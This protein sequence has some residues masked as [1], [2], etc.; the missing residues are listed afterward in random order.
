MKQVIYYFLTTVILLGRA[1]PGGAEEKKLQTTLDVTYMS[2]LMDKGGK[3]YGEQGGLLETV[4]IDLWGTGFG[5]KIGHREAT[6]GGYVNKERFDY[7]LYYGC[8]LL[9]GQVGETSA[10][11]SAIYHQFPDEPKEAGN[12]YEWELALAW[13]NLLPCGLV[14]N[15]VAACEYAAGSGYGNRAASGWY[16]QF[17]LAYA[18][19]CEG[20][21]NSLDLSAHVAYR[22]GLGGGPVDHDWSHANF[23]VSTAFAAPGGLTL[24]PAINYEIAMDKSVIDADF[25]YFVLSVKK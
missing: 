22:D 8:S 1:G 11:L 4:G 6:S 9:Q 2:R 14:P 21:Q 10:Q 7:V 23:G 25:V 15:Y 13:P 5:A 19:D 3:Y 18:M 20:L 12:Y 17:G 16:H 24:V